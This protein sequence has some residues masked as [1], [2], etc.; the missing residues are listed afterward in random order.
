MLCDL[1]DRLTKTVANYFQFKKVNKG[2]KKMKNFTEK[3]LWI[4]IR[5]KNNARFCGF[6]L[7]D[8]C[9]DFSTAALLNLLSNIWVWFIR[10]DKCSAL[11]KRN[12]IYT[13]IISVQQEKYHFVENENA[14]YLFVWTAPWPTAP[15]H[16]PKAKLWMNFQ[17]NKG[18]LAR[19][20]A[21]R[22][23]SSSGIILS[24]VISKQGSGSAF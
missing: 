6:W 13:K 1:T 4:N 18:K 9:K 17:P 2:T 7:A 15:S 20:N 5:H 11:N 22:H 19:G 8:E 14:A 23:A 3:V 21:N 24:V 12:Y 10:N 16:F